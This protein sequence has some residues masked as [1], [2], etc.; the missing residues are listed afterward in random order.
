VSRP[1]SIAI[2]GMAGLFPGAD[3]PDALWDAVRLRRSASRPVPPGRWAVAPETLLDPAIGKPDHLYSLHGCFLDAVPDVDLAGTPLDP[4]AIAALDPLFRLVL[5]VGLDAWRS[6]VT[7]GLDRRR[8]GVAMANIALPTEGASALARETIGAALEAAALGREAPPFTPGVRALDAHP[9]ALPAGLL[10]QALGLGGG[11]FTL[12]AACASS[13]YA[14]RLACDDLA[15]GRLDAVLAGGA[16][17][18]QCL[19]TQVGFSQLQALSPSGR[20][21]PFDAGADGLVVGE[22][23][24]IFVLKRLDDAVAAGDRI[25]GVVRA[26]GLSN[27]VGGSLLAPE[28]EGQLRAMRAAYQAAGWSPADVDLFECHGTGTARGD[29]VEL[30]SLAALLGDGATPKA[31]GSAHAVMS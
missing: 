5:R 15:A 29:A 31:I 6:A 28:A 27:D 10:A 1:A 8:V 11:S 21:A 24:A 12:D 14:I 18:P 4:A 3:G 22:G 26:V 7:D 9:A 20:C 13:L 19:Y 17:R 16:S 30:A 23:A 2:V 25:L